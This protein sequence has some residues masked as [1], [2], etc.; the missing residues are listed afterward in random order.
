MPGFGSGSF[1][2]GPF[3]YYDW[4]KRVLFYDLPEVPDR[5]SDSDGDGSLEKWSDSVKPLFDELLVFAHDFEQL[6]DPDSIR[7]QYQE[8][9]SVRLVSAEV[10]RNGRTVRVEVFDPDSN[11]P[12]NPLGRTSVG[13]V[14]TDSD[15]REFTVTRVH[16]L[17]N[18]VIVTGNI[19][20]NVGVSPVGDATLRPP[21]LIELLGNDYGIKVDRH[22]PEVF[23]RA[24]VRNAWQWLAMKGAE[25]AYEVIGLIAGYNVQ[26]L[27]LWRL[28]DTYEAVPTTRVYEMP[29]GSGKFYT[30]QPPTRPLLDEVA[31]DVIPLDMFCWES[32]NWTTEG[33]EP[34]PGPLSDGTLVSVAIGS[35]TQ[36]LNIVGTTDLGNGLW[37]IE[38]NGAA[39]LWSIAAP[40]NWYA[41]FPTGDSGQFWLEGLPIDLGG[42]WTFRVMAGAAP[43]FGATV[44][45]DYECQEVADCCYC[46]ASV[47]RIEVT[48]GEILNEP[49]ANLDGAIERLR[50]RILSVVPVHVRIADIVHIIGP[51]GLNVGVA[52]QHL[53]LNG[54]QQRSLF[55][56]MPVGYYFDIVPADELELDPSHLVMSGTQYTIP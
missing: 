1:G 42:S 40:E 32:P 11:D 24:A 33:I 12:L 35:Y 37:E 43:V 15:G 34:P 20:P 52:G 44:N 51:V 14:L 5:S 46:K 50:D 10:E 2:S 26:A 7:T 9:I 21:S 47:I 28:C 45:F 30:D 23:Q 16:K 41:S 56:Y 13:W 38:V 39:D 17:S 19:L 8:N 53:I 54:I 36:G 48:P 49:T 6:R 27:P 18:A 31:A 3:G 25:R 29:P 22:D 55:A 4:S